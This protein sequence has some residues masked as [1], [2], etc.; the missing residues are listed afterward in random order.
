MSFVQ[1][2]SALNVQEPPDDLFREQ[3]QAIQTLSLVYKY[4]H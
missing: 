2:G 4:K 3:S 1:P